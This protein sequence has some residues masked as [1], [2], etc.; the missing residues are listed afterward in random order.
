[1]DIDQIKVDLENA[2]FQF[3]LK[4]CLALR[5]YPTEV[6]VPI[7]AQHTQDPEFLVRTCVARE[8]GEHKTSESFSALLAMMRHDNTPNVR[9]EAAN[10][11][12]LAGP[13]SIPHLVETFLEDEHWLVRRSILATLLDMECLPEILKICDQGL[14]GEDLSVQE[15]SINALG[16]I[17]ASHNSKAALSRLL[18]MSE[19]KNVH[20][21]I[22]VASALRNLEDPDAKRIL[23]Q[24]MLDADPRVELAAMGDL[25]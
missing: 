17:A 12:S 22:R 25:L 15:A 1:M 10:A 8:L 4:A 14:K 23:S 19:L 3:R 13:D 2:D 18:E 16:V 24:M 7:L 6:S 11:L 5:E 9:A 21:R 20:L